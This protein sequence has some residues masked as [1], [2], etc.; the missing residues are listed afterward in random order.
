MIE[1]F[2]RLHTLQ[3]I[4]Y[5]RMS[6]WVPGFQKICSNYILSIYLLY[7]K[8]TS[9][10]YSPFQKVYRER[11]TL[12]FHSVCV[13]FFYNLTFLTISILPLHGCAIPWTVLY[14]LNEIFYLMFRVVQCTFTIAK[15][16]ICFPCWYSNILQNRYRRVFG[17]FNMWI[18]W[19]STI[20]GTAYDGYC[21]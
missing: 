3:F 14:T 7:A 6:R 9:S 4:E 12:H 20:P 18:V 5:V 17:T 1:I 13:V 2:K 15:Y 19:N 10:N 16:R 21:I 8:F 11:Q